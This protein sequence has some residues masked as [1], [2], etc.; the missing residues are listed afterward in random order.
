[1]NQYLTIEECKHGAIYR[2]RSRNLTYGIFNS[3]DKSFIGIREKFGYKY[4][5]PE[6]H[7]SVPGTVY[8]IEFIKDTNLDPSKESVEL[9]NLLYNIKYENN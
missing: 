2:I 3:K 8:P 9:Y 4:L 7:Y 6:Y 5:F 1:M